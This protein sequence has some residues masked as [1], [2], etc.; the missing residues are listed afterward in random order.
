MAS[1]AA[2]VTA[3]AFT[4]GASEALM[5]GGK[6]LGKAATAPSPPEAPPAPSAETTAVQ[7][8]ASEAA[9]RRSRARGQRS[10]L[11]SQNFLNPDN[12]GLQSTFGS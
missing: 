3:G 12:P 5:A 4:L 9:R 2:R 6:A 11:L 7:Q 1:T 8:A 10:T